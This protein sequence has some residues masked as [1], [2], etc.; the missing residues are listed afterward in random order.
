MYWCGRVEKLIVE[1][2][3][4]PQPH[5]KPHSRG[6]GLPVAFAISF[7]AAAA[8]EFARAHKLHRGRCCSAGAAACP[9]FDVRA[10]A[11][12]YIEG[13]PQD[14][15]SGEVGRFDGGLRWRLEPSA[16]FDAAPPRGCSPAARVPAAGGAQQQRGAAFAAQQPQPLKRELHRGP[17]VA[18]RV[19]GFPAS[20]YRIGA[21]G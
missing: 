19:V 16:Q 9:G 5:S 15:R 18:G 8:S 1:A 21:R 13:H 2:R 10:A 7:R 12:D 14:V 20:P 11:D 3:E 6:S 17:R 4:R